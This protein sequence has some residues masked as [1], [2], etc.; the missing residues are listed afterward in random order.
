MHF[1]I[2][3]IDLQRGFEFV[4][5]DFWKYIIDII[6]YLDCNLNRHQLLNPALLQV[7]A[8][9]AGLRGRNPFLTVVE[10]L[11]IFTI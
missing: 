6:Y 11:A 8:K 9:V 4:V 1:A 7:V 10:P 5:V 3:L 2:H